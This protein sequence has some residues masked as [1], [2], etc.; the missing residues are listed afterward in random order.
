[1]EYSKK[2]FLTSLSS[3]V[4][5]TTVLSLGVHVTAQSNSSSLSLKNAST[6]TDGMATIIVTVQA[7]T[8]KIAAAQACVT[9]DTSNLEYVGIS[10]E[11]VPLSSTTPPDPVG[12]CPKDTVA[13]SRYS[14]SDHPSG[15]F[16]L[17]TVTFKSKAGSGE[18]SLG[19]NQGKSFLYD[20]QATGRNILTSVNGAKIALTKGQDTA[21]EGTPQWLWG[22]FAIPAGIIAVTTTVLFRG[23]H[24]EDTRPS[25]PS[26]M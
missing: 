15:T 19:I 20:N 23:R 21:Q 7:G 2:L 26:E 18:A 16:T 13:L 11:D 4:L 8:S 9:Y 12:D 14:L 22:L 17:G 6:P 3:V 5:A 25:N 24:S 10:Y 1:M